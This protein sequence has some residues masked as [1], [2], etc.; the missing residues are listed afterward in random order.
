MKRTPAPT[1][2]LLAAAG[3]FLSVLPLALTPYALIILCYAL[4]FAI[5]CLEE[6]ASPVD[7]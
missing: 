5:A 4:V 2:P 7:S 3:L 6:I 1:I